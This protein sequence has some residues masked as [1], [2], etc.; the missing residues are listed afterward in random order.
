MLVASLE[1]TAGSVIANAERSSPSS[2]GFNQVS[3]FELRIQHA[4]LALL[5]E[6]ESA[7]ASLANNYVG[8]PY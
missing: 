2:S 4:V 8:L 1:A 5:R 3:L 6:N 7:Q